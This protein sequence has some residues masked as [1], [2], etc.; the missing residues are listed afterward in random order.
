MFTLYFYWHFI[1]ESSCYCGH[2]FSGRF[3][4]FKG[5]ILIL[6]KNVFWFFFGSVTFG[7]CLFIF[8]MLVSCKDNSS[9]S[10]WCSQ[11][12]LLILILWSM[13]ILVSLIGFLC[14]VILHDG[15]VYCYTKSQTSYPVSL[16]ATWLVPRSFS[17]IASL[18]SLF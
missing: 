10:I 5:Q 18:C 9:A 13:S 16:Y 6:C 1:Y 17:H 15:N 7:S 8:K 11:C 14:A 12:G 3:S 4:C 2:P